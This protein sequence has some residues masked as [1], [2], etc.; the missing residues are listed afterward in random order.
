MEKSITESVQRIITNGEN[1]SNA[2]S[3]TANKE[4][5]FKV[6]TM[7]EI[8]DD[9]PIINAPIINEDNILKGMKMINIFISIF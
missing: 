9:G 6:P 8:I 5:I 4:D 7:N 2:Q 3:T 1:L